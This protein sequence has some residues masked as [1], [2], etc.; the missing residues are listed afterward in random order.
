MELAAAAKPK[1]IKTIRFNDPAAALPPLVRAA[2]LALALIKGAKVS[3]WAE[4]A[5]A[6]EAG[7]PQA[8]AVAVTTAQ[9][10]LLSEHAAMLGVLRVGAQSVV[11]AVCPICDRY[12]LMTSA[13]SV[14]KCGLTR[15]CIGKPKKAQVATL[16]KAPP[17]QPRPETAAAKPAAEPTGGEAATSPEESATPSLARKKT[18]G[19]LPDDEPSWSENYWD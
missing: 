15:G 12:C 3:S 2:S 4:L 14:T 18:S 6:I 16:Y 9:N 13:A 5:E 11:I 17:A 1:T 19:E 7:D 10:A 8:Q